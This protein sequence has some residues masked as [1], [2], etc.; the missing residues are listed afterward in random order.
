MADLKTQVSQE[1]YDAVDTY[2]Q[3]HDRGFVPLY[4]PEGLFTYKQVANN[5][6]AVTYNHKGTN[7]TGFGMMMKPTNGGS[8]Q[9]Y[10]TFSVGDQKE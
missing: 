7:L 1:I 8:S 5:V 4:Q 3:S 9:H 6:Y 10:F 2:Y